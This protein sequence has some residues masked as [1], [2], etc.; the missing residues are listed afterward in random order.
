M[1]GRRWLEPLRHCCRRGFHGNS[2]LHSPALHG[3]RLWEAV[4][5]EWCPASEGG[6]GDWTHGPR[7]HYGR[8]LGV[9]TGRRPTLPGTWEWQNAAR[10]GCPWASPG[11][12][13]QL[14]LAAA[15]RVKLVE[16]WRPQG[17]SRR[18]PLPWLQQGPRLSTRGPLR[19]RVAI[20][21]SCRMSL[22]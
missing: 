9:A 1:E 18:S 2:L 3:N 4:A 15:A 5:T 21:L 13:Q 6:C 10:T 14:W 11:P 16:E 12:S 20:Y 8:T 17:G 19:P 22:S 7:P